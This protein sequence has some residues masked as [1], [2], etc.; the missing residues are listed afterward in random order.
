MTDHDTTLG[1]KTLQRSRSFGDAKTTIVIYH[2]QDVRVVPLDP[3]AGVVLG[4]SEPADIV[5]PEPKL[6]RRHA[7]F[8]AVDEGVRVEDLG[9]TNGTHFRG[10][11]IREV[12]LSGGESVTLGRVT[13]SV[14]RAEAR[15]DLLG[16]FIGYPE[17]LSRLR[18]EIV[19][20]RTYRR[21]VAVMFIRAVGEDTHVSTWA[22]QVR[23]ALRPV[24]RVA[25]HGNNAAFALV[26]ETEAERARVVADAI[27]ALDPRLRIGVALHGSTAEEL[28]D[29]ARTLG[30]AATDE[31]RAIIASHD[32]LR[33]AGE[34]LFVSPEMI[35]LEE[36]L[37]RVARSRIP[38]LITGETG[39][40]KEIV[41]QTIHLRGP[42]A[43]APML[44][45]NCGV[46]SAELV[47]DLIFGHEKGAFPEAGATVPGLFERCDGGTLFLDEIGEL[48]AS[49]QAA[50]LRV[51][52]TQK[53]TRLGSEVEIGI[54]VRVLAATNRDL[55]ALASEGLFRRDL[56]FRLAAI[57]I[58]VPPL[59]ERPEDVDPFID[60]FLEEA[61]VRSGAKVRGIEASA[62]AALHAYDWPGNVRELRNVI[63]RAAV[64]CTRDIVSL[65]DLPAAVAGGSSPI[66][67]NEEHASTGEEALDLRAEIRALE[68]RLIRDALER[69][70]GDHARAAALLS[71]SEQ[72]LRTKIAR[73]G[74]L[75]L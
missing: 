63:E 43:N 32:A 13:V 26:P 39:A 62:R 29:V 8:T 48:N 20:T 72:A 1:D 25:L 24:D 12:T 52:E 22:S 47:E 71:L 60:R 18:D 4:R 65:A 53:V 54:D 33:G 10:E 17:L 37:D 69:A 42:R 14:N 6:S 31:E 21:G 56:L 38:A 45:V 61:S 2:G 15:A 66:E 23:G 27:I 36:L 75:D 44:A 46:M 49:A 58:R 74:L 35:E 19:R 5:V 55:S 30:A 41:A 51:L 34:P 59:R 64:V 9:S 57:T 50:L 70:E 16:D 3:G 11:R 68:T 40:G 28:I 67:A 73:Y 7:R